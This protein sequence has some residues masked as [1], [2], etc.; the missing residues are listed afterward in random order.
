MARFL[1]AATV[2]SMLLASLTMRPNRTG[3]TSCRPG[4]DSDPLGVV[5]WRA[6]FSVARDASHCA[7]GWNLG[8][9]AFCVE[10]H[11]R[12]VARHKAHSARDG[13]IFLHSA[14]DGCSRLAYTE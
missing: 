10:Y 13:Y 5:N 1:P 8:G 2:L 12:A 9:N 3:G 6:V 4:K 14:I 11:A 7:R